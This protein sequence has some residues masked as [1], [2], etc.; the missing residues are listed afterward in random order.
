MG[1][2]IVA[3]VGDNLQALF[4]GMKEFPTE[5][6]ILIAQ[7]NSLKAA[8]STRRKLEQF[9]IKVD[10][11]VID[12]NLMEEMFKVFGELCTVYDESQI[13]VNVA[14]GDRMSTCAAL[15]AA[16][17]NG[18]KAIGIMDNKSF[19]LPIMKMSYYK[20]ISDNKFKILKMIS[21]KEFVSLN[22]LSKKLGI[23]VSLLSYH[24][25]GSY[26]IKGLKEMR[27][28]ESKEEGKNV[29]VKL[30]EMGNLL[31]KGY[32]KQKKDE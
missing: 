7:Q 14:T 32:V 4:V 25:N 30:S 16:F 24:I 27:L 21:A 5:K 11:R 31:L 6:V 26:N 15:S 2:I 19:M 3:P 12:G 23:S 1:F 10:I 17:A 13:I 8:E 20:E 18:L 22:K 28:V 9:T 29:L